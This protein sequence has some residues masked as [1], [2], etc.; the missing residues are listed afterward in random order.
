MRRRPD[1]S[2]E[3][4]PLFSLDQVLDAGGSS[5]GGGSSAYPTMSDPPS[6]SRSAAL[7]G[8]RLERYGSIQ[9]ARVSQRTLRLLVP[10]FASCEGK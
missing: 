5:S 6:R 9:A 4:E 2:K 8:Q 7:G 3:G 1:P 10:T